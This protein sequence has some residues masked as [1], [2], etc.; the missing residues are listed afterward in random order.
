MTIDAGPKVPRLTR[1]PNRPDDDAWAGAFEPADMEPAGALDT[2]EA[3]DGDPADEC[4]LRIEWLAAVAERVDSAPP[5][6]WLARPVWPGDAY[7]VLGAEKKAGKTWLILDMAVAVASG[8][9]WLGTYP[10]EKSGTVLVFLG[11]GGE[12]KMLRRMRAV[13]AAQGTKAEGLPIRVCHRV[14]G[15]SNVQHLA[16]MAAEVRRHRPVLLVVDPLYIAAAGAKGSDLYSMASV[17]AGV[18]AL[19]QAGGAA[20][21]LVTHWN[22]GGEGHGSHRMTGV[23]PAEWGR[24]LVSVGV[25]HRSTAADRSTTATLRVTFEGDEIPESELRLRRHIW[26]DDPDDLA[27][28]LHY[29]LET[30]TGEPEPSGGSGLRP[31]ERR[32][33]AV[34]RGSGQWLDIRQIGDR[35]AGDDTGLAPLKAR[36]IQAAAKVLV[37]RD[38][39]RSQGE[40]GCA[41]RWCADPLTEAKNGL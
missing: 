17:L 37:E 21:I 23:G 2:V 24:V 11:E 9:R 28:P 8:G 32:V 1:V 26:A 22:K 27:S 14:P 33:L 16:E 15:L 10:C 25:E 13:A 40:P 38:F 20:L 18:Q 34:L 41:L 30:L 31:A 29:E 6:P 5:T 3:V 7:G 35:L 4:A 39:A 12:R 36:T 19:C